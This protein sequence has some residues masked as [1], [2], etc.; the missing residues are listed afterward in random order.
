MQ[1]MPKWGSGKLGGWRLAPELG[2]EPEQSARA[3]LL[4]ALDAGAQA[5]TKAEAEAWGIE[6][7]GFPAHAVIV[8]A[9]QVHVADVLAIAEGYDLP[10]AQCQEMT[11][12]RFGDDG[13]TWD[14][15]MVDRSVVAKPKEG[16]APIYFQRCKP[17]D[18][19]PWA[20]RWKLRK[21]DPRKTSIPIDE[22]MSR[23]CDRPD[24]AEVIAVCGH[25]Q[26]AESIG[27]VG[28]EPWAMSAEELASHQIPHD[29][30][31]TP[32]GMECIG[33]GL[34]VDDIKEGTFC[35][36]IKNVPLGKIHLDIVAD[37]NVPPG[38][39]FLVDEDGKAVGAP[40]SPAAAEAGSPGPGS[41]D[42]P[43]STPAAESAAPAT[44]LRC[45]C[46]A[47]I[48]PV[49]F[50]GCK[51][52][53]CA[54]KVT[55]T[56]PTPPAAGLESGP[57]PVEPAAS[58]TG[59]DSSGSSEP[60]LPDGMVACEDCGKVSKPGGTIVDKFQ[61]RR[62][63]TCHRSHH[64]GLNDPPKGDGGRA[65]T[66]D[67]HGGGQR[68]GASEAPTTVRPEETGGFTAEPEEKDDPAPTGL[69]P[70]T[71][72]GTCGHL[73]K[74]HDYRTGK[75]AACQLCVAF[76]SRADMPEVDAS[77]N[78]VKF[79]PRFSVDC[80]NCTAYIASTSV[81]YSGQP[82]K[83]CGFVSPIVKL[84]GED[85]PPFDW[86]RFLVRHGK[87]TKAF[88]SGFCKVDGDPIEPGQEVFA[89]A[90][91][92]T[93]RAHSACITEAIG[94]ALTMLRDGKVVTAELNPT[95]ADRGEAVREMCAICAKD[96]E[97]GESCYRL[98][99]VFA[100]YTCVEGEGVHPPIADDDDRDLCEWHPDEN[101]AAQ[102]GDAFHS[103]AHLIV[104]SGKNPLRLC[105]SCRSKKPHTRKRKEVPITAP[106]AARTPSP[107]GAT[108]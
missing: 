102:V 95:I 84:H 67:D 10:M 64:M 60:D 20:D 42:S 104:G 19:L 101:R 66:G 30:E 49:G 63:G 46:G 99:D 86:A 85:A 68:D 3:L 52:N 16:G 80:P 94:Y 72:C 41:S 11:R 40:A 61:V 12:D 53:L 71:R 93:S 5:D 78:K 77:P 75:C 92:K 74:E 57:Q 23:P 29:I 9:I 73:G 17:L 1:A 106:P 8:G 87:R 96:I 26:L 38:V 65:S 82:C 43:A 90:D 33:C 59:G 21:D 24:C 15:E 47:H 44:V 105:R 6:V 2:R 56:A 76:R 25:E 98:K 58:A 35:K 54:N 69:P 107:S 79:P 83:S 51:L 97:P 81:D 91:V 14:T 34:S 62:C 50:D 88:A 45:D 22:K 108:A 89:H 7:C 37:E 70:D 55:G 39:A 48:A 32:W 36:P 28:D 100:H 13:Y 27:V 103:L 18:G 31:N 4:R